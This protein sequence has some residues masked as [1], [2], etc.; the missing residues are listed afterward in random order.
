MSRKKF[1]PIIICVLCFIIIPLFSFVLI[2]RIPNA[3]SKVNYQTLTTTWYEQESNEEVNFP[4]KE[5]INPGEVYTI[6]TT[7]SSEIDKYDTLMFKSKFQEVKVYLNDDLIFTNSTSEDRLFGKSEQSKYHFLN[8]PESIKEG[9]KLTISY[10]SPYIRYSTY[11]DP[12]KI[13]N[14][15][16]LAFDL[17]KSKIGYLA[18]SFS[19]VMSAIVLLFS[20][21]LFTK[22]NTIIKRMASLIGAVLFF[23]ISLTFDSSIL[24][25][26]VPG[27]L[28]NISYL[29]FILFAMLFAYYMLVSVTN[30][31]LIWMFRTILILTIALFAFST[32]MHLLKIFDLYQTSII[33]V[34][35]VLVEMSVFTLYKMYQ[36]V[37]N[38]KNDS[39]S[40]KPY[41]E[42]TLATLT[43]ITFIIGA[44][45]SY[46]SINH[47]EIPCLLLIIY[48]FYKY[49]LSI[50]EVI[51]EARKSI[52]Y[53]SQLKETK[54]YLIQSQMKSH[55][56]F[57]T[58]GAIRTMIVSQP[59][60]AYDM[61]T[62]FTKYLRANISNISP[63]E[64]IPFSQELDHIQA[65]INIEKQRFQKRL[66]V[67]FDIQCDNFYIPPL[68]V[69][70]LVENAVKH[71]VCK[72]LKGGTVKIISKE[73]NDCYYVIVEDNG[74]GFDTSIL[75]DESKKGSVG[76]KYIRI[77]LEQLA[78]AEFIIESE[79][80]KGT[81]A[82]I[83][84]KKK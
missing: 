10:L 79:E 49:A 28:S 46:S 15:D 45:F 83:I 43:L 68:S 12:V 66:N 52:E 78:N 70:P 71:G 13:G 60:T 64:Q 55:F 80:K 4:I 58:L 42:S 3:D 23:G 9:D 51:G 6:Y 40:K 16:A 14:R 67:V 65:Y 84:I 63:N 5:K 75:D 48:I 11:V 30:K 36:A 21:L 38:K 77:R 54:N 57:N 8:L 50:T 18:V 2:A 47:Y 20:S 22:S 29:S 61:M 44:A 31:K 37:E 32:T 72:K 73:D 25:L 39:V 27:Y 76:L 56:I 1:I 74:V 33:T 17:F 26:Y 19:I 24:T 35:V 81:K 7:V 34:L 69:E 62:N 41:F 53:E 59:N 82:T